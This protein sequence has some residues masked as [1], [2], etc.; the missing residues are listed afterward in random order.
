MSAQFRPYFA[1]ATACLGACAGAL[2][3]GNLSQSIAAHG[4]YTGAASFLREPL[5]ALI[6]LLIYWAWRKWRPIG[7]LS[8][9]AWGHL[10][11]GLVSGLVLGIVLPAIALGM[12]AQLG[13]ATIKAPT[14]DPLLLAVPFLALIVHGL[15]EEILVRGIAQRE[16]HTHFGPWGGVA[17]GAICF[18]TLQALQGYNAPIYLANSMFFGAVL[19]FFALGRGG[20]WS[21]VGAHAGWSW[22]ETAVLGARGQID[23]TSSWLA[24]VGPDSYGSPL[25]TGVLLC[26]LCGQILL[27]VRAQKR[28]TM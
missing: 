28:M 11:V 19:G 4:V 14:L 13:L 27:Q 10:G 23:K 20:I 22:L 17:V 24:G 16:G 8:A 26:V 5:N 21:A 18:A 1:S 25:F 6:A 7:N 15:A 2:L 12:M 9:P 3:A